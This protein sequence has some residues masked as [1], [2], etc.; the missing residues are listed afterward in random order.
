LKFKLLIA[1]VSLTTASAQ[2]VSGVVPGEKATVGSR[3]LEANTNFVAAKTSTATVTIQDTLWYYVN[4]HVYRNTATNAQSFYTYKVAPT[5]TNAN[6]INSGG[7]VFLKPSGAL[8]VAVSGAEGIVIKKAGSPTT[9]VPVTLYLFNVNAGL[10]VGAAVTSCTTSISSTTVGNYVGCDFA[11]PTV[12]VGDY[13]IVMKN[14]SAN[15]LDTISL[16][17]NNARTST[18]NISPAAPEQKFGAAKVN[19]SVVLSQ[20]V[21]KVTP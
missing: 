3:I 11:T 21:P 10:P 5:Y 14:T 20:F 19:T 7:A 12:V 16:F 4:K 1:A 8:G 6:S 9:N 2:S 15:P 18:A 13:A 17:M